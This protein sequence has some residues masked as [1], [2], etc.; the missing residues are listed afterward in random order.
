MDEFRALI[1]QLNQQHRTMVVVAACSGL[2][3]S[4][5]FALQWRDID[6]DAKQANVTRSYVHNTKRE[7]IGTPRRKPPGSRLF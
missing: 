1:D 2:R 4:E 6:F 7:R 3:R 5:L